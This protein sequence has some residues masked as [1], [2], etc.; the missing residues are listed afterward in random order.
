MRS[1]GEPSFSKSH[2]HSSQVVLLLKIFQ[3]TK[4]GRKMIKIQ[5]LWSKSEYVQVA[6]TDM[7]IMMEIM[8]NIK[9]VLIIISTEDW[10][11]EEA[12]MVL[13]CGLLHQN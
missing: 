13:Q 7:A 1:V 5:Y 4:A 8:I 6:F 3:V 10:A 12:N 2:L 9:T 11:K